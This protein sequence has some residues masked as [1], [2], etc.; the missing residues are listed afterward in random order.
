[1]FPFCN[2][3]DVKRSKFELMQTL[4]RMLA[5]SVLLL[6]VMTMA[7]FCTQDFACAASYG[8]MGGGSGGSSKSSSSSSSSDDYYLYDDDSSS[9][10][11]S[12]RIRKSKP[13]SCTICDC[14]KEKEKREI[15]T[16]CNCY[17]EKECSSDT[18]P[19]GSLGTNCDCNC[20]IPCKCSCHVPVKTIAKPM[21]TI[22]CIGG[23][24]CLIIDVHTNP[25]NVHISGCK[26]EEAVDNRWGSVI[27]VQVGILDKN[28]VLQRKLNKIAGSADTLT[29]SG[30]NC[31]LKEVVK[32]LLEH[33]DFCHFAYL[34]AKYDHLEK[35]SR[36]C[37]RGFL[38]TEVGKFDK[39]DETFVNVHGVKFGKHSVGKVNNIDNEYSVVTLLVLV[40][41]EYLI[42][43][44]KG[45]A[46]HVKKVHIKT[47]LQKIH[48]IPTS[49]L[50]AVEVLWTPQTE[51]DIVSE[52]EVLRDFGLLMR[53][54]DLTE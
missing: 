49:D 43:S 22:I 9:C 11:C 1:M 8:R 46:P 6:A 27:M 26:T 29:K 38:K 34:F 17:E 4:S 15:C 12:K 13:R 51:S 32:A 35:Y 3:F 50:E 31:S 40:D 10:N 5:S 23:V 48:S 44:L 54:V 21:F 37:F 16:D 53:P 45:Y 30:L 19:N 2:L 47:A 7:L 25:N 18:V 24:I 52:Q 28:R 36:P 42:P 20:H 39:N 41:G 33:H 14:Y